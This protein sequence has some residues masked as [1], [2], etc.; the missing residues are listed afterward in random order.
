LQTKRIALIAVLSALTIVIAYAR[1]I[2]LT[3]PGIIEFMTVMIFVSGFCFGWIVGG[4]VGFISLILY[5]LIPSPFASPAAWIFTIS[6]VLLL[7][8]GLLGLMYGVVGGFL[9]KLHNPGKM[10]IKFIA[11]M[12]FWGFILTFSYDVLSS[13]GFYLAYAGIYPSV[14]D[15]IYMTFIPAYLPYPPII[16]TV[17]NTL[18]FLTVAPALIFAIRALPAQWKTTYKKPSTHEEKST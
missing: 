1:G 2:T 13:I 16:H 14:W 6:P 9:G 5:M 10:T 4:L 11:E 18:V 7:I 15:A 3:L 8:M 12:A 17:T